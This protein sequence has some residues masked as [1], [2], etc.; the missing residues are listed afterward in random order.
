MCLEEFYEKFK[1]SGIATD[2][3][4]TT[5]EFVIVDHTAKENIYG[6]EIVYFERITGFTHHGKK[7]EMREYEV[8]DEYDNTTNTYDFKEVKRFRSLTG[9][10]CP[11]IYIFKKELCNSNDKIQE[12]INMFCLDDYMRDELTIS[13]NDIIMENFILF[14][15]NHHQEN[16][17]YPGLYW[18][19]TG[20]VEAS[21]Q[22]YLERFMNNLDSTII[23]GTEKKKITIDIGLVGIR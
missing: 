21:E 22:E 3:Y 19:P 6:N 8:I 20:G 17:I 1:E 18:A 16:D 4:K 2:F 11:E 14:T 13:E 5:I 23:K 15:E 7:Y 9:F 12:F 10:L